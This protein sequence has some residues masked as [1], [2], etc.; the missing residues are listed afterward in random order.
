MRAKQLVGILLEDKKTIAV[1]LDGTLARLTPGDFDRKKI[2]KPVPAMLRKVRKALDDGHTVMIFTARASEPV[3]VKPVK[4]WLKD[5]DLPALKV[6]H[7]K[8]P[9]IDEIWDDK[10][11]NV[12][13]NKGTF[14]R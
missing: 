3:N 11:K 1:D 5:N 4:D 13:K 8:T 10:A 6:T 2:G 14:R 12:V 7:E 9:D